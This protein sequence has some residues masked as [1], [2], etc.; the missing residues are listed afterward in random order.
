MCRYPKSDDSTLQPIRVLETSGKGY[1]YRNLPEELDSQRRV[2]KPWR[3]MSQLRIWWLGKARPTCRSSSLVTRRRT[4]N[5]FCVEN[6]DESYGKTITFERQDE[7]RHA[8]E[9]YVL[10]RDLHLLFRPPSSGHGDRAPAAKDVGER[11][12]HSF[13]VPCGVFARRRR[14]PRR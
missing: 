5:K 10:E 7:G 1:G 9:G 4:R 11:T 6:S 3:R 12:C 8:V 13:I 14:G 2:L